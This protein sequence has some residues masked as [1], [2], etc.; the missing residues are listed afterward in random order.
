MLPKRFTQIHYGNDLPAQV[1]DALD[2]V[3]SVG[4]RSNFRDANDF[5][6]GADADSVR[7]VPD[8]KTDDLVVF[9]HVA[10][11]GQGL[12]TSGVLVFIAFR[13]SLPA[14]TGR[15]TVMTVLC[16]TVDDKAVHVVEQ[17]AGKLE[18]LLGSSGK[19]SGTRSGLL[20]EFAHFIH[21]ADDGLCAGSLFL[22][23][24][25]D[26][27]GDFGEAVGG[28][29]DLRGADGLLAGCRTDFL[30]ELVD[31]SDDVGDFVESGAEIVAEAEDPLPRCGC[32][33]SMFS[34]A[35]RASR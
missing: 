15:F 6:N 1:D 17:V 32:C 13:K 18:H 30:G 2:D 26:F 34:T 33:C 9:L 22:N 8:A 10:H 35:W 27:L 12:L 11:S 20:N 19:F 7:L 25:I 31:F 28:L 14:R 23:G 4:D 29:S 24:G 16:G 5:A 21:G 3:R